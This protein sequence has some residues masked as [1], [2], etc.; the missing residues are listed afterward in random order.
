MP[1]RLGVEIE[2]DAISIQDAERILQQSGLS[3]TFKVVRD[4]SVETPA[5]KKGGKTVLSKTSRS[6]KFTMGSEFVSVP[7]SMD[8]FRSG[9]RNLTGFLQT[10]GEPNFSR[11]ASVHIHIECSPSITVVKNALNLFEK[12][13]PLFYR[14]G[15]MGYPFRGV[16]N[17]SIYCRPITHPYGPPVICSENGT[18]HQIF[19][20]E[21]LKK[22]ETL[23]EFWY[24]MAVSPDRV[25]RYHPSRYF[26]LN[27]FSLALHGTLEF[28][29]FNKTLNH[30]RISAVASLCL[31]ITELLNKRLDL[32]PIRFNDGDDMERLKF[33][34]QLIER[35][36]E[37]YLVR[38]RDVFILESIITTT[39]PVIF[40]DK[41]I[42]SHLLDKWVMPSGYLNKYSRPKVSSDECIKSG[43]IDIHNIGNHKFDFLEMI[44]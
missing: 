26:G 39:K 4:A 13:E 10:M 30:Q 36:N 12:I 43:F 25:D 14:L 33:V 32:P 35:N 6:S 5:W 15:G 27:L 29:Y 16:F 37:E 1:R 3:S 31:A 2:T 44:S 11:R 34:L 28:R 24:M 21:D 8:N 19:K 38:D 7:L 22:A 40:E 42:Y 41:Y 23:E 17:N 9:V 20:T 18:Y